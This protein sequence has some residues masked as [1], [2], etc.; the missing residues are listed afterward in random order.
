M[1]SSQMF[2]QK[3]YGTDLNCIHPNHQ[4]NNYKYVNAKIKSQNSMVQILRG[5]WKGR[6]WT[7]KSA[8]ES[9]MHR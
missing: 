7:S 9:K 5:R 4:I 1:N 8:T 6:Y 2:S 3:I